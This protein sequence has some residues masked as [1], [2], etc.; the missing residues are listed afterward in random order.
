MLEIWGKLIVW[1][2]KSCDCPIKLIVLSKS[3]LDKTKQCS[4]TINE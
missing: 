2:I 4:R 1:N 3:Q